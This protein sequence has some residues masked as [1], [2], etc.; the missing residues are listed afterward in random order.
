ME[1]TNFGARQSGIAMSINLHVQNLLVV[2]DS[3]GSSDSWEQTRYEYVTEA[4][5]LNQ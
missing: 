2:Q 4:G 1:K 3:N 5:S